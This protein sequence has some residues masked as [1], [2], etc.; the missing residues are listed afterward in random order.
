MQ[1]GRDEP[2]EARQIALLTGETLRTVQLRIADGTLPASGGKPARVP[3]A[4]AVRYLRDRGV[5]GA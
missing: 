3:A 2:I 1:L 4:D 5:K